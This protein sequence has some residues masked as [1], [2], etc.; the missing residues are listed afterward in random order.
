MATPGEE[1][2]AHRGHMETPAARPRSRRLW[3]ELER[4]WRWA[5]CAA[6]AVCLYDLLLPPAFVLL[7]ITYGPPWLAAGVVLDALSLAI[8]CVHA[9]CLTREEWRARRRSVGFAV[10]VLCCVPWELLGYALR[11]APMASLRLGV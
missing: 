6:L 1:T 11:G 2:V 10:D 7:D 3:K 4:R 5:L 8:V 9:G